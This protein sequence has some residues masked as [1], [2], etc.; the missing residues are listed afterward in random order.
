MM[1]MANISAF[2]YLMS[3]FSSESENEYSKSQKNFKAK[4]KHNTK[5]IYIHI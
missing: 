4:K 2:K 1:M 3:V 5:Y